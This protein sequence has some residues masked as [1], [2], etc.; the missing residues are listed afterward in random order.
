MAVPRTNMQDVFARM[1]RS[2]PMAGSAQLENGRASSSTFKLA[3]PRTT[4][5]SPSLPLALQRSFNMTNLSTGTASEHFQTLHA[6]KTPSQLATP[7]SM[8]GSPRLSGKG[9]GKEN[10]VVD[11]SAATSV[12]GLNS[13]FASWS[14]ERITETIEKYMEERDA[15][16]NKLLAVL[17][18]E[19]EVDE[20]VFIEEEVELLNKKIDALKAERLARSRSVNPLLPGQTFPPRSSGSAT[21]SIPLSRYPTPPTAHLTAVAIGPGE[22]NGQRPKGLS[23][24]GPDPP[25][26]VHHSLRPRAPAQAGPSRPA[27]TPPPSSPPEIDDLDIAAAEE[28]EWHARN[29]QPDPADFLVPPSS[30]LPRPVTPPSR[31][32][33][34]PRSARLAAME[35]TAGIPPGDLLSPE[36]V[37]PSAALSRFDSSRSRFPITESAPRARSPVKLISPQR[38]VPVEIKHPWTKEVEHKLRQIFKLPN[39]RKHQKEAI[40]ETMAGKDVFVLMPTGGGKSLTYQLPAVCTTGKTRG[41]TVVVSPLISLINDQSRHLTNLKIPAIAYTGDMTQKDKNLAHDELRRPEPYTK[42]VY[43]T[44]EML[45]MGS[46]IKDVLSSLLHR[47]RLARFVIDEAHCVSQWGH[48]FRSDYLRLGDLRKDY[49]GVPIMALTATAQNKVEEDII[50][51]LNIQ[52]CTVLRQSFNRPNLHYEVRPKKKS[53]LETDIVAFIRTQ[54]ARSSGIIYCSSRD[55]CET[56]AKRLRDEHN[57]EAYHYHAGMAKGDRRKIQE[58]WQEHQ[59]EIIVATIAFGMGIDKP[60]VRFVIHH[61]VPRS[62]EGYYQETGRAGRDGKP[63]TCILFYSFADGKLALNQ[64]SKDPDMTFDQKERHRAAMQEVL[65]YCDNKIDCRRCQVLS[66]FNETFE[67]ANCRQGCDVCLI[68]D[69]KVLTNEDVSDDAC[70]AIKLIQARDRKENI[71]I[72]M[73]AACFVGAGSGFKENPLY[74]AGKHWKRGEAL[75]LFQTLLLDGA[76]KEYV[77]NTA[78]G[79]SNAYLELHKDAQKYLNGTKRL[80]MTFEQEIKTA[81]HT[82]VTRASGKKQSAIDS[83]TRK[84]DNPLV[85]KRSEKQILAEEAEFD[86]SPWDETDDEY[87]PSGDANDPIEPGSGTDNDEDVPLAAKKRK[88]AKTS[89]RNEPGRAMLASG[90]SGQ[91]SRDDSGTPVEACLKAL[92]A[93]RASELAKN[94]NAPKLA[95]ETLQLIATTMPTTDKS[96]KQVEGMTSAHMKTYM[97][98]ILGICVKMRPAYH[99]AEPAV[100]PLATASISSASRLRSGPSLLSKRI[101]QYEYNANPT[102][103]TPA[104]TGT[105]LNRATSLASSIALQPRTTGGVTSGTIS[106]NAGVRISGPRPVILQN[107][108]A[109]PSAARRDKF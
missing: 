94:R 70:Q 8:T 39:F 59:F 73:A 44:P 91:I 33:G 28:A 38:T 11:G 101:Q 37:K 35:E 34:P 5:T 46:N 43:V 74:G 15:Y 18:G 36:P 51:S 6:A 89:S 52:G 66:F 95:D 48:D 30:P 75:R 106:T 82:K 31:N 22:W 80:V 32:V 41:V 85:R 78:A 49:P 53:D 3:R 83:Y 98:R 4:D 17:H 105:S 79:W 87:R 65:R 40:N 56:L 54:P 88:T 2:T 12:P 47:K 60:D 68:R 76:F 7:S 29:E 77:L 64:I 23:S 63:S 108:S 24:D 69:K 107:G 84:V 104:G 72:P 55:K 25:P 92:E 90:R 93:M 50:R 62:L 26:L 20:E 16:K 10:G 100:A 57:L 9:K 42:V 71:T 67:P 27:R 61:S 96:L 97:T 58:G 13:R 81:K 21:S 14:N 1:N 109:G 103:S 86:N 102:P 19:A 45:S 99:A